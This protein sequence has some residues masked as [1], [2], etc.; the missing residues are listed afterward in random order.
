MK[1]PPPTIVVDTREQTPWIPAIERPGGRRILL[2]VVR[3]KLNAGD[4]TVEGYE[5]EIAIERKSLADW[6]GTMFSAVD[7]AEGKAT[8]WERFRR[9]LARAR[10]GV[11]PSD[12]AAPIPPLKSFC[13]MVEGSRQDVE[14]RRYRM[15]VHPNAVR[16]RS[17]SVFADYGVPVFWSGLP[18]A[19]T[20]QG[21]AFDAARADMGRLAMWTLI[22]WWERRSLAKGATAGDIT[23]AFRLAEPRVDTGQAEVAAAPGHV[24]RGDHAGLGLIHTGRR[25]GR[26]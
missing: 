22:R 12:G 8:S 5:A 17:D 1:L 13:I 2:P 25:R 9:E 6:I 21:W 16:G 3:R 20:P 7:T 18:A 26:R 14:A 11:Q 24:E 4:Y 15:D 19:L 23:A 10:D